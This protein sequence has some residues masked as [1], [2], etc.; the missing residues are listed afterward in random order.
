VVKKIE[1]FKK[2]PITK[3]YPILYVDG[4]YLKLRRGGVVEKEGGE[5]GKI[6]R[7]KN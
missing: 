1:E 5:E 2:A 6:W 4:T 3:W 7:R